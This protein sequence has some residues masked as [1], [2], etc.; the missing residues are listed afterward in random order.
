MSCHLAGSGDLLHAKT[1]LKE[2]ATNGVVI[3]GTSC[4]GRCDRA[5]ACSISRHVHG[6]DDRTFHDRVYAGLSAEQLKATVA[7]IARGDDPPANTPD[8]AYPA[9]DPKTWVIDVYRDAGFPSYE[10]TRR[11]L[12]A[13]PLPIRSGRPPKLELPADL[14]DAEIE[15]RRKKH[16]DEHNKALHPYLW[17]LQQSNLLG[18]G[19]AGMPGVPEVARRLAGGAGRRSTSSATATRA[20]RARSRTANSCCECPHLVVEGRDPRAA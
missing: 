5:P 1:G 18:M 7:A 19:G 8:L 11:F 13:H 15:K 4:L 2:V 9:S 17:Q 10:A 6:D 14:P 12:K 20:S 16:T 3:A